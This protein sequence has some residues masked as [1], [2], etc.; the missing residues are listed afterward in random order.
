MRRTFLG[1]VIFF[2]ISLAT[3]LWADQIDLSF[4]VSPRFPVFAA[5]SSVDISFHVERENPAAPD[6][7]NWSILDYLGKT[8]R[9]GA[10]PLAAGSPNKID[11]PLTFSDL[12]SGYWEIHAALK[13]S[14]AALPRH[15]SQPP[16][17]A[18]FGILPSIPFPQLAQA[19]EA[20]FGIQG[21]TFLKTG[22]YL[23]GDSY[24]PLYQTLGV[25][26]INESVNWSEKEPDHPGQ[27]S[28][29]MA[30]ASQGEDT[31]AK[32]GLMPLETAFSLPRWALAL[33]ADVAP[34]P[35]DWT[36]ATAYPPQDPSQ[37]TTY[38]EA[39]AKDKAARRL[40]DFPGI[41]QA[42]YQVG[43]EPDWHWRGTDDEFLSLYAAAYAGIHAGDPHAVVLGPGYGVLAKG[44]SLLETLLPKGLGKS[45]DGIAIHGY[46][47]P[48]G[49]PNSPTTEGRLISP[50]D[51]GVI[52]SLRKVRALMRQ[53]LAPDAKLFQTEW[54]L[55]YRGP[56]VGFD[57]ALLKTHA[58][59]II[60]GH[61]IFLGEGCNVTYFFYA[62]DYGSLTKHG[63]DGY[64]LCFNLTLPDPSYGAIQAAPKPVFM[65]ACTLTR[66]LDGTTTLGPVSVGNAA[67]C[68]YA[69]QGKTGNIVA[70]WS[71]DN[72]ARTISLPVGVP[73][74]TVV[75]FMGNVRKLSCPQNTASIDLNAYPIYL[76]GVAPDALSPLKY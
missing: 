39:V 43:W 48:F 29:K 35:K 17:L 71:R 23:Q 32:D 51:A 11:V 14:G 72:A 57:P 37:Y 36:Q 1:G 47:L 12:P 49:N 70:L 30:E 33:P 65:A 16:G 54:G 75:D 69:F 10:I 25:H 38:L 67:V 13:Q 68:A 28:A 42:F 5:E 50:E 60:R 7:I 21:T 31:F 59:Y 19:D 52:D 73:E 53:Y 62:S 64:G 20:R 9:S 46:Y 15:G 58:A 4:P 22:V 27:Y 56:Y 3:S 63:E 2:T 26:W 61:L 55:D 6:E 44:E 76:Q 18:S 41:D 8:M 74:V 40:R 24:N 66:L 34:N 45:L